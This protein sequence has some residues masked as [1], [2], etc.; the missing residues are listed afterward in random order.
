MSVMARVVVRRLTQSL[1]QRW[2]TLNEID[3]LG[4]DCLYRHPTRRRAPFPPFS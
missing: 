2:F 3:L 1:L 4:I